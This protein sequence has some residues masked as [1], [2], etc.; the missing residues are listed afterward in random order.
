MAITRRK[1]PWKGDRMNTAGFLSSLALQTSSSETLRAYRQ[2]L[3]RFES[4]LSDRRLRVTQVKRSTIAEFLSYLSE[5]KGRTTGESLAPAT[6]ARQL[7]IVSSYFDYLG[8]NS[9]GKIRNPVD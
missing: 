4:F 8:D 7:S 1:A 5:H 3:E 9:D 6:I 2:T